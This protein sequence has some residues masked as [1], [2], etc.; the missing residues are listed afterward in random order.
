MLQPPTILVSSLEDCLNQVEDVVQKYKDSGVLR[1]RGH[2]F[3][4]LEQVKLVSVLGD[5]FGWHINS[6][7]VPENISQEL[8]DTHVFVGGHSDNPDS[9]GGHADAYLL[10][11]HIEQV[12]YVDPFLAGIWNMFHVGYSDPWAGNTH[13]VDS[14]RLYSELNDDIKEFLEKS[15]LIWDK[16]IGPRTGFGPFYTK[17]IDESPVDGKKIIRIETDGGCLIRPTLHKLDGKDPSESEI[18]K[19]NQILIDLKTKLN[20]DENIRYTQQW[21]EDDIIVVDLFRMYHAVTGGFRFGERKFHGTF[22]RPNN[23]TNNHYNS[24]ELFWPTN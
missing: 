20:T 10:D 3:T 2:K 17:A 11:W 1:L 16:P 4:P 12:F 7:S 8:V 5:Y 13:F 23:Y 15:V 22:T 6:T 18:E 9:D 14:N 19:F 21:E 24:L